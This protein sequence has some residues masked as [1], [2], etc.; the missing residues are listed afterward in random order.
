VKP[1]LF[2]S[3]KTFENLTAGK[4]SPSAQVRVE[5]KFRKEFSNLYVFI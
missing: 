2:K 4:S 1:G 3:Q 5:H